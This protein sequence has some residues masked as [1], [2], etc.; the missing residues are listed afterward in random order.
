MSHPGFAAPKSQKNTHKKKQKVVI[1]SFEEKTLLKQNQAGDVASKNKTT[2]SFGLI[3]AVW[4]STW[5][6]SKSI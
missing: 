6:G 4:L 2:W 1:R 3:V 5:V